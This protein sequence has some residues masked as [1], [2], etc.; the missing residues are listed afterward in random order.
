MIDP[1]AA[2]ARV[3]TMVEIFGAVSAAVVVLILWF[4]FRK[5]RDA[6]KG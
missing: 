4:I 2:D 5:R 3:E 6:G 1:A